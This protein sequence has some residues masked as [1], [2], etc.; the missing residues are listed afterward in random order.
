MRGLEPVPLQRL[1]ADRGMTV[2][3]VATL[4]GVHHGTVARIENGAVTATPASRERIADAFGTT[5]DAIVWPGDPLTHVFLVEGTTGEHDDRQCWWVGAHPTRAAATA[6]IERLN[7]WVR[8]RD[9]A[10]G[11]CEADW[12][13]RDQAVHPLDPLFVCDYTGTGYRLRVVAMVR[14]EG[15]D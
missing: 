15:D 10:L 4:S 3:D 2:R 7:A 11:D 12:T 8:E 13:A 6:H 1:R 9:M 14:E 5:I